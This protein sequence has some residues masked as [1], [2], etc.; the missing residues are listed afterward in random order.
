M[1]ARRLSRGSAEGIGK[2]D[3]PDRKR[4]D[5]VTIQKKTDTEQGH[6][7]TGETVSERL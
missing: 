5:D 1:G 4:T 3:D 6:R 2:N 7:E